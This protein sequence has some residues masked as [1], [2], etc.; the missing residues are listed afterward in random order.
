MGEDAETLSELTSLKWQNTT[1]QLI[2]KI[3]PRKDIYH[4]TVKHALTKDGWTITH[5]QFSFKLGKKVLFADLGAER[6]IS[7]EKKLRQIIVEVKSFIGRSQVN[8]LENALGQYILYRQGLN[9]AN[10][11][12]ELYL[13]VTQ[14]TFKNVFQIPLGGILLKNNI[15]QLMVFDEAKEVIVQW[16]PN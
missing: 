11:N 7:A 12:R 1:K 13:A 14:P 2:T 6:V 9:E 4:D 8:D 16:L 15:I 10:I 3:M 5:D